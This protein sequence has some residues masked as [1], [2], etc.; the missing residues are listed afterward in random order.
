VT[1][2]IPYDRALP[3]VP[4]RAPYT[5]PDAYLEKLG[6]GDY[7]VRQG[8]R[9]S[10]MFLVDKLC[11]AVD[12][13]R[14]YEDVAHRDA[15]IQDWCEKI[16]AQTGQTWRYLKVPQRRFDVTDAETFEDLVQELEG[17]KPELFD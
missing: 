12:Q 15:S 11:Q 17:E 13:W 4:G 5:R 2:L 8:R 7:A 3:K 10:T 16:S 1:T 9:P 14:E 6:E